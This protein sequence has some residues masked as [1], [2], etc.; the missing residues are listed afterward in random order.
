M[1]LDGYEVAKEIRT[2]LKKT[3]DGLEMKPKLVVVQVGEDASSTVYVKNKK[4]ACLEVGISCEDHKF[5]SHI[6]QEELILEIH[7]LNQDESVHGILI[8]SPLPKHINEV[9][10]FNEIDSF[11]DVDG[12][13]R[14]NI[15]KLVNHESCLIP[16]TPLGVIE[17]LKYYN[18]SIASS[19]VVILG[20]S[21]V[22]GK[23]LAMLFLNENASVTILHSKSK[24]VKKITKTA[25]ILVSAI[26]VPKYVTKDM[27]KKD[28]VVIDV[29]INVLDGKIVGDVD[30]EQVKDVASFITPVPKGVGPMTVAM[31]LQNVC[32]ALEMQQ[33]KEKVCQ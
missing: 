21:A 20:R 4:N 2:N 18:I 1:K 12:F 10:L 25:D 9:V 32:M 24:N 3:I 27:V 29:G 15:G 31:L 19:H 23:P 8:Q 11:K 22:V 28:A 33:S 13:T 17:L 26:G 6:T 5:S 30:Y 7:K 16:C 14:Q